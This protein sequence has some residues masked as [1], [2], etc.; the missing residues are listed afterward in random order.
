MTYM[1]QFLAS[2]VLFPFKLLGK[3]LA[4]R[5]KE[6]RRSWRSAWRE[7]VRPLRFLYLGLGLA[8]AHAIAPVAFSQLGTIG[9]VSYLFAVLV[10][11][12]DATFFR[13][14]RV[15][16]FKYVPLGLTAPFLILIGVTASLAIRPLLGSAKNAALAEDF[17]GAVIILGAFA[18]LTLWFRRWQS[19]SLY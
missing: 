9:G 19:G 16:R 1:R 10:A 13:A 3:L 14:V 18:L 11:L 7:P 2:V 5:W 12:L 8:I 6:T 17:V 4:W 15:G